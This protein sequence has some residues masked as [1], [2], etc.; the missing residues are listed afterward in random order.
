MVAEEEEGGETVARSNCGSGSSNGHSQSQSQSQDGRRRR[1]REMRDV[2]VN[3][4]YARV[5]IWF[6]G[7]FCT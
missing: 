7:S 3:L 5:P 4:V 2:F 1:L 6:G